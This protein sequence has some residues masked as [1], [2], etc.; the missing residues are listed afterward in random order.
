MTVD[1]A[2]KR[3]DRDGKGW[4]LRNFKLRLSRKL[5]FTA[6]L[7]MCMSCQLC[8]PRSLADAKFAEPDD[9]YAELE[10]YLVGFSNKPPL[11]VVAEFVQNFGANTAGKTIF[12]AYDQF[13]TILG[14]QTK[15]DRLE[16]L[17]A[18]DAGSDPVFTEA[19]TVGTTFQDGL[20]E[21]FFK[22][23]T[24]LTKATQRYGVF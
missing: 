3:R 20:T 16:K 24:E 8:P 23:D 9:F 2:T 6:G 21:L 13:L 19:R 12:D 17:G 15:R 5:T 22:T 18:E 4:A 14:D 7:A 11:H 10:S 1:Y